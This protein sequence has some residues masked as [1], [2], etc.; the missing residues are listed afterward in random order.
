MKSFKDYPLGY[1]P[2]CRRDNVRIFRTRCADTASCK[3]EQAFQKGLQEAR[4]KGRPLAWMDT[5]KPC[6]V[7]YGNGEVDPRSGED[8]QRCG[9]TGRVP[10][11]EYP[12]GRKDERRKILALLRGA[13]KRERDLGR[14]TIEQVLRNLGLQIIKAGKSSGR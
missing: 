12:D 11:K 13:I 14:T 3:A 8:C 5:Y 9:A 2:T 7:C 4:E 1:C 6:P 10:L